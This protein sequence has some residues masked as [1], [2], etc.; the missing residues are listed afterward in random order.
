MLSCKFSGASGTNIT[1]APLPYTDIIEL[2]YKLVANT[3]TII[4]SP[5]CKLNGDEVSVESGIVQL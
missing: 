2:P 4:L 5:R 1:I 3:F